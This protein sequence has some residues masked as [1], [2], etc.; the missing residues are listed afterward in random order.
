M[1]ASGLCALFLLVISLPIHAMLPA[2]LSE[3]P[4]LSD[5]LRSIV[6]QL[7]LDRE[8]G[9]GE[10]GKEKISL[11]VIDLTAAD[12][13]CLGG[14]EMD[15]FIYPASV[16]KM[17]VAAAVL[18]LIDSGCVRWD[19]TWIV[20]A[21]NAV[22]RQKEIFFDPRPLLQAEDRVPVYYLLDL[23]ISRSDNSAANCL[24]DLATRPFIDRLLHRYGWQGSEVTRKFLS[25]R[26]EDP[27]YSEVRGTETCARH[28]A[29]FLYR[30]ESGTLVSK[31]VSLE[32]KSLLSRQLDRTKLAGGLP[33]QAVFYHKTGWW[34]YW[35]HDVGLVDSDKVRYIIACF[36][37]LPEE[38]ALSVYP[39]LSKR[40][41]DLLERRHR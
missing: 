3:E 5:S 20:A 41:F 15:N 18:A 40:I 1:T 13:P 32:L 30:M 4:A 36:L 28:A 38:K 25:R 11:A 12:T 39:E 31:R 35:T 33:R 29:E 10:D 21:H 24:I 23:M 26:V 17:Y 9:V 27:G 16:Y 34:S 19:S 2:G 22:D 8:F 14:V 7:G 6:A 37:P